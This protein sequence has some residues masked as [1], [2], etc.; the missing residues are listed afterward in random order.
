MAKRKTL[1]DYVKEELRE[2]AKALGATGYSEWITRHGASPVIPYAE[3]AS[4]IVRDAASSKK[5]TAKTLS[6]LS[7][8]GYADY[9][10]DTS[11]RETN[12][13]LNEAKPG[14]AVSYH[15]SVASGIKNYKDYLTGYAEDYQK[16]YNSTVKTLRNEKITDPERAYARAVELGLSGSDARRAADETSAEVNDSLR[17]DVMS[18]IVKKRLTQNQTRLY[19]I[20]LGLS[21]DAAEELAKYAYELNEA[22]GDGSGGYLDYLRELEKK[23]KNKE[24]EK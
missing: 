24:K 17:A 8:S 16:L 18:A 14:S 20:A 15:H 11:R 22:V 7:S 19:A 13:M 10:S 2:R 21:K 3:K 1:E 4:S 12:A 6:G 9:I 5:S 23:Q